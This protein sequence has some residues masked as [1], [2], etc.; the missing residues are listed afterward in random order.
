MITDI[1]SAQ[2]YEVL[3]AS[4]FLKFRAEEKEQQAKMKPSRAKPTKGPNSFGEMLTPSRKLILEFLVL[5]GPKRPVEISYPNMPAEKIKIWQDLIGLQRMKLVEKV[6][7]KGS[8][9]THWRSTA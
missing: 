5:H 3:Y 1:Q 9:R 2:A 6:S 8:C 7:I 4:K